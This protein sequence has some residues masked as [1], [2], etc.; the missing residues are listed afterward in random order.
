MAGGRTLVLD[1]AEELED[2]RRTQDLEKE[3]RMR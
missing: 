3:Q 1:E 2:A